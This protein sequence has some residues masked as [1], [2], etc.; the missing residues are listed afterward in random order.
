MEYASV[1]KTYLIG[2]WKNNQYKKLRDQIDS[3]CSNPSSVMDYKYASSCSFYSFIDSIKLNLNT[4][5]LPQKSPDDR[6]KNDDD[7]D[8]NDYIM[9]CTII[10]GRSSDSVL[11]I[12]QYDGREH[13][14]NSDKHQ[15]L[16]LGTYV[17]NVLSHD[18]KAYLFDEAVKQM[19]DN[20]NSTSNVLRWA[21]DHSMEKFQRLLLRVKP[22][23]I[24]KDDD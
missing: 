7:D 6:V 3:L 11:V 18:I 13:E 10:F 16:L 24:L 17:I 14:M 4:F 9:D 21:N 8:P 1:Q 12:Y 19:I 2:G 23:P 20:V 5:N 15:S 22:T